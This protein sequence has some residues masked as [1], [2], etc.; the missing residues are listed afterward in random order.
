MSWEDRS[1]RACGIITM[2]LSPGQKTHSSAAKDDQIE[3]WKAL[4]TVHA[5][6]EPGNHYNT[7]DDLFSIKKQEEES[8]SALIMC[9]EQAVNLMNWDMFI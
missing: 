9:T 2:S 6:Q 8:L 5:A 4:K 3:I 1:E 7:Y